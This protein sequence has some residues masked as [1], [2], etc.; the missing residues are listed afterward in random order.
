MSMEEQVAVFWG[1]GYLARNA[2]I[3]LHKSR[4]YVGV[5]GYRFV[6]VWLLNTSR[7]ILLRYQGRLGAYQVAGSPLG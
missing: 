4:R 1:Q 5:G 6:L 3:G 2:T 7:V